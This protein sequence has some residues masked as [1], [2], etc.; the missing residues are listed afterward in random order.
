MKYTLFGDADFNGTVE[1]IDFNLLATN[2]GQ[3]GKHWFDGDFDYSGTVDTIDFNLLAA[4]FGQVLT[5]PSIGS[6]VPEPTSLGLLGLAAG[7][8]LSRRRRRLL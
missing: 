1:T 6:L 5:A 2:F 8:V 4:N 3:S 7:S